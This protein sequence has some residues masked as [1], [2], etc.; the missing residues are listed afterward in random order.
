MLYREILPKEIKKDSYL[1]YEYFLDRNHPL[2]EAG[3]GKVY[4]HRHLASVFI[5]NRWIATDEVVHHID[6]NKS[7]NNI[8]N[9]EVLS[10]SEHIKLHAKSTQVLK[11]C[12]VCGAEFYVS[13]SDG[14]RRVTCSTNC[15]NKKRTTWDISK[16]ELEQLIWNSSYSALSK[17]Y[18]LSDVG[19]KKRAKSLG[20]KLPP[21]YFFNKSEA[22]RTELRKEN[23]IPD[24]PPQQSSKLSA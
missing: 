18:P 4:Y 24:L 21:A 17:V 12:V 7:N 15:S 8:S 3:V 6:G 22:Y 19:I 9:L 10:N 14:P 2:S 13:K 5:L 1:G 20:C 23:N 11:L 16:E